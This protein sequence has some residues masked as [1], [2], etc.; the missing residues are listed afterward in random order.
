MNEEAILAQA[1]SLYPIP[2]CE[3]TRVSE[4]EGGRNM[5][6]IVTAPHGEKR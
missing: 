3:L 4:H 2:S 5:V 6:Y 1:E